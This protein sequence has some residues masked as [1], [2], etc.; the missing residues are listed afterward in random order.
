ML[1]SLS[2]FLP[3]K[4]FPLG[5]KSSEK[6][7]ALMKLIANKNAPIDLNGVPLSTLIEQNSDP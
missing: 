5:H 4:L 7:D 6:V 2:I 3:R 1:L